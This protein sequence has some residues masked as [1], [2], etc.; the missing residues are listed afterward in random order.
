MQ[1]IPLP[2]PWPPELEA[3][4]AAMAEDPTVYHTMN[5]P[6]EFHVIGSIRNWTIIDRLDRI[7]APTLLISGRYDEATQAVVQPFAD[8][9]QDVSWEIFENSSHVPHIEETDRVMRVVN[10]FLSA[11]EKM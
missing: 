1:L 3:S 10:D 8:R 9:I 6:S 4:F 2:H 11:H 7:R 5:G